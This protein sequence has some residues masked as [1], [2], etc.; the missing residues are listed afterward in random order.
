[1]KKRR[2]TIWALRMPGDR[3]I[4]YFFPFSSSYSIAI[5]VDR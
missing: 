5:G 1:M 4:F 3:A 2:K